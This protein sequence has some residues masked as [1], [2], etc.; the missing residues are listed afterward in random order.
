LAVLMKINLYLWERI[1]ERRTML[2][3][4]CDRIV[5]YCDLSASDWKRG[6][7]RSSSS[8]ASTD[9]PVRWMLSCLR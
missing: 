4:N 5:I 6:S 7:L 3:V 1:I 8:I 2:S 9:V